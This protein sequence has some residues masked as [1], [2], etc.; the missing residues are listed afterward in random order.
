MGKAQTWAT[1]CKHLKPREERD[2]FEQTTCH[3]SHYDKCLIIS[4]VS[5]CDKIHIFECRAEA[6]ASD[7]VLQG[8]AE[9]SCL[10]VLAP[11][12]AH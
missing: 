11:I 12:S 10:T 7:T 8:L 5:L 2:V 9:L 1:P 3:L 4:G 6:A